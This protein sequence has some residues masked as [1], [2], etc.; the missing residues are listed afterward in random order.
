M[1]SEPVTFGRLVRRY[2][3]KLA[4]SQAEL[5]RVVGCSVIMVRKIEADVRRPSPEIAGR[6]AA[7]LRVPAEDRAAFLRA[8][9]GEA[10]PAP[11]TLGRSPADDL[12]TQR[13]PMQPTR[14]IGREAE[15]ES[16]EALVR[17]P[18]SRLLTLTGPGGVGKTRLAVEVAARLFD[19]FVDG[20]YAAWLADLDD[21]ARVLPELCRV[22]DLDL[23]AGRDPLEALIDGLRHREAL[24]VLNNF[25]HLLA[26]G[27][28]LGRLLEKCLRL[29]LLVTSR[30]P[31]RIRWERVV[32]VAPLA[33]ASPASAGAGDP[34]PAVALFVDR[35]RAIDPDFELDETNAGAIADICAK[36]DGLP[37]GIELAAARASFLGPTE[38]GAQL[39]RPLAF[40]AS[41][42]KDMPP[43]HQGLRAA[44]DWSHRLLGPEERSL[45]ARLA[46]FEGG[47]SFEAAAAVCGAADGEGEGAEAAPGRFLD[48]IMSLV[49]RSL[50]ERR[51]VLTGSPGELRAR[52][53]F[54]LLRTTRA[55]ALERLAERGEVAAMRERHAEH[56]LAW[57]EARL[58]RGASVPPAERLAIGEEAPNLRAA[59]QHARADPRWATRGAAL[60]RALG[61][62]A[63]GDEDP[64]RSRA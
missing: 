23:G 38:I 24:I 54:Y 55:Y 57:A 40:L 7:Q 56:F 12:R 46:V 43:R 27:P 36:V 4:A 25:E 1:P 48:S 5:A 34:S 9:R 49:E 29:K 14:L 11:A 60:D 10:G 8:A 51:E 58:G 13:F 62:G 28:K 3:E 50:V 63:C 31:L 37:L 61:L 2:R 59:V 35:L 20:A 32:P 17:A 30:T 42:L 52:Q 6:L 22:L 21:P 26:A 64:A 19:A 41:G 53:R 44:L 15:L 16:L 18:D 45:F 33:V 39:A 47:C